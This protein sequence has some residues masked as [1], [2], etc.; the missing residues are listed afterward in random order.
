LLGQRR[1]DVVVI[2]EACQSTEP[3]AWVPLLR[4]NKLILAAITASYRLLCCHP[5][6]LNAASLSA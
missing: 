2:D 5:K 4:A 6:P 3:A 1:F